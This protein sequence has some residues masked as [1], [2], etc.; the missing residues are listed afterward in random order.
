MNG[1]NRCHHTENKVKTDEEL[2]C[3]AGRLIRNSEVK[4]QAHNPGN[5]DSIHQEG[6]KQKKECPGLGSR[7]LHL[8]NPGAVP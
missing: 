8:L 5:G 6:E 4:I 3:M 7:L 1:K 2:V